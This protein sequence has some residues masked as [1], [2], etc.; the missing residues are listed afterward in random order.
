MYQLLQ[1]FYSKILSMASTIFLELDV[2]HAG[3][4]AACPSI[5]QFDMAQAI[6]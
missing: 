4:L 6:P 5:D 2:A 3:A 1:K